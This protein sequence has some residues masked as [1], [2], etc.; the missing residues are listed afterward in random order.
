MAFLFLFAGFFSFASGLRAEEARK[1][2]IS[3]QALER[4][5]KVELLGFFLKDPKNAEVPK[6]PQAV[7]LFNQAVKYFQS[8]DY[9]LARQ[10]L[11]ESIQLDGQNSFAYELLG[12][13]NNYE[14]K[15]KEAKANYEIAYNLDPRANLK[16]KIEKIGTEAHVDKKLST[17]GEEHF[18]IKYQ[19]QGDQDK[20]FELRE[21][22][23]TTYRDIS[24]DFGYYFKRKVVVLLYEEEDF[25][26]ITQLPH[27][28]SGVY[29]GK[30]R[31]PINREGFTD[32]DLKAL[33]AHEV[34]H[35][36]IAGMSAGRAPAWINEGLAVYEEDKVKPRDLILFRSAIKTRTLMSLDQLISQDAT[37]SIEDPLLVSLFYEEAFQITKYLM[38]R[39]GVYPV[40]QIL[41][42]FGK[43]K[44]SD[45]AIRA[46]LKI[47]PSR[48]E[49][50]WKATFTK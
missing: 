44:N 31:M 30:V 32:Q 41:E 29:D 5:Q 10:T 47:S 17:Y 23:R 18:V 38:D 8:N 46:V 4:R 26:K 33:T 6:T 50:E 34:T 39:Y 13:I 20:G 42:Q 43:G 40:K 9:E 36:F 24:R 37:A 19:K 27:W 28:A 1:Q 14:Q 49:Q 11:E 22:L 25:K 45:E 35:A 21:L 16:E 12:D 2:S 48:L 3:E 15:L 7:E